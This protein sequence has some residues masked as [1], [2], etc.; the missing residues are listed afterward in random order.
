MKEREREIEI[1]LL[2]LLFV[3]VCECNEGAD[4]AKFLGGVLPAV[5]VQHSQSPKIFL[6]SGTNQIKSRIE[7]KTKTK[8]NS[9]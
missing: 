9:D 6:T 5:S 4:A 7:K 3:C 1:C 2:L 8:R